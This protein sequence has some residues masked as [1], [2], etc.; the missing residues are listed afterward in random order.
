MATTEP[1]LVLAELQLGARVAAD[2]APAVEEGAQAVALLVG[3]RRAG[4]DEGVDVVS[5]EGGCSATA[6]PQ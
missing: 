3:E 5:T 2:G 4:G 1:G 6:E